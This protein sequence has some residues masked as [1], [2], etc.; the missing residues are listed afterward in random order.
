MARPSECFSTS[1]TTKSVSLQ[2][3]CGP[4]DLLQLGNDAVA[5]EKWELAESLY[6][7][8]AELTAEGNPLLVDLMATRGVLCGFQGEPLVGL[9]WLQQAYHEHV[10][11]GDAIHAGKDLFN[12][13]ALCEQVQRLGWARFCLMQARDLF[14]TAGDAAWV[15]TTTL[16]LV[17]LDEL[18][19]REE[20]DPRWN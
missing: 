16:S 13:A 14:E 7:S 18:R 1:L 15:Q 3:D 8:A 6:Q 2:S 19:R 9:R 12:A 20:F 5:A 11:M 4:D 10:A 17:R